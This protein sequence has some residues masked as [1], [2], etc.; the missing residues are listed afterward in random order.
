MPEQTVIRSCFAVSCYVA[1]GLGPFVPIGQR[2]HSASYDLLQL[3][4]SV[5]GFLVLYWKAI[6]GDLHQL[7]S[8]MGEFSLSSELPEV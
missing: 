7:P 3:A 8:G 6:V 2:V 5:Q 1:S 4:S